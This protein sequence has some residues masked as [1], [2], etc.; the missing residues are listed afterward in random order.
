VRNVYDIGG[1]FFYGLDEGGAESGCAANAPTKSKTVLNDPIVQ[2]LSDTDNTWF[3]AR[4]LV[5]YA[6]RIEVPIHISGAYQDEQTG[7]RGPY[8][9]F[10]EVTRA[11]VRRLLMTNGDHGTQQ[12]GKFLEPDRKAFLDHYLR[13]TGKPYPAS[14]VATFLENLQGEDDV[15][16]VLNS[17][18]FPLEQ[19]RWTNVYLGPEGKLQ[20]SPAKEGGSYNYLSGSPR[21]S[22]WSYQ[23][24]HTAGSPFTTEEGSDGLTFRSDKFKEPTALIGPATAT[25]FMS[26]TA[27]DTEM[28][29][30]IIDEA[31]DG[32][33]YYVQR[34]LLKASHR[35]I[36][37]GL[38]DKL[39]DGTI[40]RP[41][42]PH[43]NPQNVEPGKVY[44]YLVEIFPFGHVFRPG[45]QLI[46]KITTPPIVDS[47]YAY[48]PKRVPGVN[49]VLHGGDTASSLMLPF[50]SLNGVDLKS[51]PKPCT[52]EDVRCTR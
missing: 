5:N 50:V 22:A 4:S 26:S 3:Q 51:E 45:H 32:S 18:T 46:V 52:L 29:V 19:T 17:R 31:P 28:F 47:Y 30:Q 9:L 8:H 37:R 25:L 34:G 10:E 38:S 40:Y 49:T 44:K 11:P 7:P 43:T 27:P 15:P 42:R 39:D 33:R 12:D 14:S 23:A 24:G 6:E 21:Q 20:E 1:G 36:L 13:G 2:G 48:V 41:H 35:A 16:A